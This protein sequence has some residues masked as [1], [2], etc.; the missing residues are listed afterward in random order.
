MSDDNPHLE[1]IVEE[2]VTPAQGDGN[3]PRNVV[4]D[5]IIDSDDGGGTFH[6]ESDPMTNGVPVRQGYIVE[7]NNNQN[8]KYHNGFSVGFRLPAGRGR[9]DYWTFDPDDPIWAKLVDNHGACPA[10]KKA[11]QPGILSDPT[12]SDGNRTLTVGNGNAVPQFFGF[13]LRF[14][15]TTGGKPLIYDPIGQNMNGSSFQ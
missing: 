3:D 11:S 14:V 1:I 5:V 7:F 4:I 6:L 15:S 8:G 2:I 13:A 9:N 12:L 10:N